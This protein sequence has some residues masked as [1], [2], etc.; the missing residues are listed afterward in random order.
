MTV[1]TSTC[2]THGS[3][4]LGSLI[5][6]EIMHCRYQPRKHQFTYPARYLRLPLSSLQA[7]NHPLAINRFGIIS[8]HQKDYGAKDGSDLQIWI[9]RLL[10]EH[11]VINCTD[12]AAVDLI[13]LPRVCGFAFNP[14]SFW[15]CRRIAGGAICAILADVNNIA[16]LLAATQGRP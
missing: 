16:P 8:F 6:G 7:A 4:P 11:A 9:D 5:V 13:T 3:D 10:Q 2:S 14:I 1:Q 15:V 12:S